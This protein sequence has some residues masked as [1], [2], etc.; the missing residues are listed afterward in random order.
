MDYLY[1]ITLVQKTNFSSRR[2]RCLMAVTTLTGPCN[3][4]TDKVSC[5]MIFFLFMPCGC[6]LFLF[7]KENYVNQKNKLPTKASCE[8]IFFLFMPCGYLLFL[9]IKEK[10]SYL[11]TRPLPP[12]LTRASTSETETRFMSPSIVCLR[13]DAAT[14]N[15]MMSWLPLPVS[16]E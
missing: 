14:A 13:A 2:R 6:L 1:K 9:F 16:M 15:S 4:L 5:E 12:F 10:V 7:S 8:M 11:C 3:V